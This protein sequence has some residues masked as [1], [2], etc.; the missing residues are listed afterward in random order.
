MTTRSTQFA[1][2]IV[3]HLDPIPIPKT[4]KTTSV[5]RIEAGDEYRSIPFDVATIRRLGRD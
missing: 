5:G 4:H 3:I 2:S 1:L